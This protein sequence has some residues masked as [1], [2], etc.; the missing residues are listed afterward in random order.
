MMRLQRLMCAAMV[1]HMET[2]KPPV[3]PVAGV[4]LWQIFAAISPGRHWTDHGPLP[5]GA[6]EIVEQGQ[7]AGYPLALRH[8]D[9]IRA[10]DRCYLDL[11]RRGKGGGPL[12]ELTAEIF[13]AMF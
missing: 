1:R 13:D 7:L 5:L 10:L 6:R 4:A 8:V 9:L 11:I 2:G 12:P 3:V